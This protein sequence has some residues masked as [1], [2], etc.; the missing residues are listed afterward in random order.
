M[1]P[2]FV[3]QAAELVLSIFLH[4]LTD[5]MSCF[6]FYTHL[7]SSQI[8]LSSMRHCLLS[9]QLMNSRAGL[10]YQSIANIDIIGI[11]LILAL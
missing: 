1:T 8:I 3:V 2:G 11:I 5:C 6:V 10:M 9:F 4:I 7:F